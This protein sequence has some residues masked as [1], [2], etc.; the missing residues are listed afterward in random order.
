MLSR[1]LNLIYPLTVCHAT[2]SIKPSTINEEEF[3]SSI[4]NVLC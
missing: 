3:G 4:D 1:P 2:Q